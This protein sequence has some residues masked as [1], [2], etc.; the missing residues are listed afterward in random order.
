MNHL[1]YKIY[2]DMR[3]VIKS[4]YIWQYNRSIIDSNLEQQISYYKIYGNISVLVLFLLIVSS[5]IGLMTVSYVR[6]MIAYNSSIS[7]YYQAYYF[8]N[9]WLELWVV[10]TNNKWVWFEHNYDSWAMI[11]ALNSMSCQH[12]ICLIETSIQSMSTWLSRNGSIVWECDIEQAYR[13]WI[14]ES[15][16]IPLFTD[17][18]SVLSSW[19]NSLSITN[20]Y[21]QP[22]LSFTFL[23]PK[24]RIIWVWFG[25]WIISSWQPTIPTDE[26][27]FYTILSGTADYSSAI[28]QFIIDKQKFSRHNN[29]L[30]ITNPALS[31]QQQEKIQFCLSSPT[32]SLPTSVIN[33]VGWGR[34]G[35]RSV[36]LQGIKNISIPD[37]LLQTYINR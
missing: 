26:D 9:A 19:S 21:I 2:T 27:V 18:S 20:I 11:A 14:W 22:S 37:F 12:S 24:P 25:L 3:I 31:G 13:L 33:I 28:N 35:N 5:L 32:Q 29:V 10:L 23:E 7:Q 16:I 6:Q 30:V 8:A 34:V 17:N 1:L 4:I 36:W 15:I